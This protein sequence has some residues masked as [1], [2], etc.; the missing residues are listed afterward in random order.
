MK[1]HADIRNILEEYDK[2]STRIFGNGEVVKST[3]MYDGLDKDG[4]ALVMNIELNA[5]AANEDKK[6]AKA[7]PKGKGG[8]GG[9]GGGKGK[10]GG[11]KKK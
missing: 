5:E 3:N 9:G 10:G 4:S 7:K 8:G 2:S 1:S 6:A 11:G